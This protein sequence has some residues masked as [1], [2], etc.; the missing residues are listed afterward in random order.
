MS[1]K[2][3]FVII[4]ITN[5]FCKVEVNDEILIM[6]RCRIRTDIKFAKDLLKLVSLV[7]VVIVFEHR[8]GKS[9]AKAA[10]SDIEEIFV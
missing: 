7:D 8:E 9:L 5:Y 3:F 1:V 10:R 6:F 2:T 4:E